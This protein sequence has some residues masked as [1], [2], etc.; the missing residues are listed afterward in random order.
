MFIASAPESLGGR[1]DF[2]ARLES[3]TKLHNVPGHEIRG[4]AQKASASIFPKNYVRSSM[5]N[6]VAGIDMGRNE[7]K[8][9]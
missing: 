7:R 9:H 2:A 6:V 1:G 5:N 3:E 8:N 4:F